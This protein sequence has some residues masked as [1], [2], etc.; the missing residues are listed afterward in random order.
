M[1]THDVFNQSPVFENVNFFT[2]DLS[3]TSTVLAYGDS[4][5]LASFGAITGS[6][7]SL[8]H[9]QLANEFKPQ[10]VQFDT[11]GNRV[12]KIKFHPSYHALMSISTTLIIDRARPNQS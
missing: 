10:L 12:D 2:S 1:A 7:S 3:L 5:G 9:G 6:A 4:K 11:K 8:E